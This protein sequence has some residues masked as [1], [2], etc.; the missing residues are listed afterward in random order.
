[1]KGPRW[2]ASAP[3][4]RRDEIRWLEPAATVADSRH[5]TA[6]E[7]RSK[8][9]VS[10]SIVLRIPDEKGSSPNEEGRLGWIVVG[11]EA[12]TKPWV[13]GDLGKSRLQDLQLS[14]R[15]YL[16]NRAELGEELSGE[17]EVS[18]GTL[19]PCGSVLASDAAW[20]SL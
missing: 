6:P 12:V 15:R 13:A 2:P 10:G 7:E 1:M 5:T 20:V 4:A 9:P 14:T 19:P 3:A 16:F 17:G 18:Q 11:G 8:D